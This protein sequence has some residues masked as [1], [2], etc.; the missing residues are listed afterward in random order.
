[1][2]KTFIT[3]RQLINKIRL[4]LKDLKRCGSF[5]PGA[6]EIDPYIDDSIDGEE[7]EKRIDDI[8]KDIKTKYK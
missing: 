6:I 3:N 1:M 4:L 7:F 5:Y 2:K 8:L